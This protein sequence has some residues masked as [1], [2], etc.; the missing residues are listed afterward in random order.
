MTITLY[1]T[2]QKQHYI[3][4]EDSSDLTLPPDYQVDTM[5][6]YPKGILDNMINKYREAL[7]LLCKNAPLRICNGRKLGDIHHC[8]SSPENYN[9]VKTFEV[10]NF[11]PILSN[12]CSFEIKLRVNLPKRDIELSYYEYVLKPSKIKWDREVSTN[13]ERSIKR[14]D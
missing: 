8:L 2:C 9:K 13:V 4:N 6:M 10:N 12:H 1:R 3:E 14:S 7:V 11:L 5:A